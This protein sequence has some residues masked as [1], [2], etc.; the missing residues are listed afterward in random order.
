MV[1]RYRGEGSLWC[2][3]ED[4]PMFIFVSLFGC[5]S[6]ELIVEIGISDMEFMWV[7][8]D[9]G[10]YKDQ[11]PERWT[12]MEV[13][14]LYRIPDAFPGFSIRTSHGGSSHGRFHTSLSERRVSAQ[15]TSRADGNTVCI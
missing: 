3:S 4:Y 2:A 7:N 1:V 11:S 6:I 14:K 5:R 9:D 8:T 10:T 13:E 12:Q 15:E